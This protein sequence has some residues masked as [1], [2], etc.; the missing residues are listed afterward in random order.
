M[1]GLRLAPQ[2]VCS[3]LLPMDVA[4]SGLF[5]YQVALPRHSGFA[6]LI[7]ATPSPRYAHLRVRLQSFVY[8]CCLGFAPHF[9]VRL[10]LFLPPLAPLTSLTPAIVRTPLSYLRRREL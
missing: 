1:L 4:P 7:A 6:P 8:C 5:F 2:T 9:R 3:L 10:F